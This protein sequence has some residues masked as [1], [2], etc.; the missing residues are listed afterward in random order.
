MPRP[1]CTLKRQEAWSSAH[2]IRNPKWDDEKNAAV[3]GKCAHT[4]GHNY[5]IEVSVK[6][7]IDEDT[8]MVLNL[9]LLKK[10]IQTAVLDPLDHK[11]IDEDVSYFKDGGV[12]SSAENIARYAF[13][14]IKAE[15]EK[16]SETP[17]ECVLESVKLWETPKNI[18]EYRG[19]RE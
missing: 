5:L 3:F 11:F 12:P 13:D 18:V 10:W 8:G 1:L 2:R 16:D 19:E 15:M 4:H 9:V 17:K 6:G 7:P 14:G